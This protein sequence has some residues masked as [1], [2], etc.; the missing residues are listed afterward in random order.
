[1]FGHGAPLQ[2]K[3]SVITILKYWHSA[4]PFNS[5][6]QTGFSFAATYSFRYGAQNSNRTRPMYQGDIPPTEAHQRL[7]G[8]S[9]AVLIDVRTQ[10]EWTFVGV[11]MVERLV[12]L[13]WQVYPTMDVNARFVEEVN[14]MGLPKDAEIMCLCRSGARSASAANALTAAGYTNCWNVAQGFEGDKDAGG[15]RAQVNGWKQA[16]L[17]W[18]QS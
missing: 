18:V 10:P 8:N 12:R 15:H 13:S 7:K 3:N 5:W 6:C 4:S 16:G 9:A 14:A 1:L 17:P 11:P 2:I